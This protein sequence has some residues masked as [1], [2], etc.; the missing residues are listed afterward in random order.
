MLAVGARDGTVSLWSTD[1]WERRKTLQA[2]VGEIT[3]LAYS[4]RDCLAAAGKKG[5]IQLGQNESWEK[6]ARTFVAHE[7]AVRCVAFS[8]DGLTLASGGDDGMV[9]TW[10]A[11]SGDREGGWSAHRAEV[12]AVCFAPNSSDLA[13]GG[14]DGSAR[15]WDSRTGKERAVYRV[16]GR[17]VFNLAFSPDG[18]LLAVCRTGSAPNVFLWNVASGN[19]D[20]TLKGHVFT[21]R[22][23]A[24]LPDGRTVLTGG[25]DQTL[26][27]WDLATGQERASLKVPSG[28]VAGMAHSPDGRTAVSISLRGAV[29]LWRST[30]D[31]KI[32]ALEKQEP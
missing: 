9:K 14:K 23:I 7:G 31:E 2:N 28:Y 3:A 18:A 21:T 13:S 29:K 32:A 11:S 5:K 8:S 24:F 6:D 15:L 22:A 20:M 17:P 25:S 4:P 27:T 1:T 10:A 26:K 12:S 19:L 16:G 30:S